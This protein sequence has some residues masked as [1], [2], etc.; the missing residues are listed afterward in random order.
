[1][2]KFLFYLF[3]LPG[4]HQIESKKISRS[5]FIMYIGRLD[6][7]KGFECLFNALRH[8]TGQV[9][10]RLIICGRGEIKILK[11][12]SSDLKNVEIL[13]WVN[14]QELQYLMDGCSYI[15]LPSKHEGYP[16]SLLEACSNYKPIIASKVSCHCQKYLVALK[17]QFFL[18][19]GIP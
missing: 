11:K 14:P 17:L 1:M 10:L 19:Q 4:I 7:D 15:I 6:L 12:M 9:N 5:D 2:E 3:G 18:I 8:V 13:G 16:L